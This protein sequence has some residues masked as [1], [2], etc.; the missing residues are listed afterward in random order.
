MK[1]HYNDCEIDQLVM[2][3]KCELQKKIVRDDYRELV[4][5]SVIFLG[6]DKE[7]KQKIRPPGAMHQARW[8]ARAIYSLKICLLQ[9]HFK[10]SMK[11]KQALRDVFLLLQQFM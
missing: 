4:E 8:M 5:L 11:E 7:K 9:S 3:Y 10:I 1:Q 2:F 6:G